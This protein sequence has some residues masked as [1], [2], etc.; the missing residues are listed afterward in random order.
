MFRPYAE[1]SGSEAV[2]PYQRSGVH[3]IFHPHATPPSVRAHI[4]DVERNTAGDSLQEVLRLH[5]ARLRFFPDL[6]FGSERD[7][8]ER[9]D[10]LALPS[11]SS[12]S[13]RGV[14]RVETSKRTPIPPEPS[15]PPLRPFDKL[16][17]LPPAPKFVELVETNPETTEP[18]APPLRP[19]DKLKVLPPAPGSTR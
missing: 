11:P 3:R 13:L 15:P 8:G 19:F 17:V 1:R 16:R 6:R 2:L 9:R 5:D 14:A 7:G 12:S 10:V 18:F 4:I